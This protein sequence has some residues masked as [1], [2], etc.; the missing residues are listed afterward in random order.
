VVDDQPKVSPARFLRAGA[1]GLM[2]AEPY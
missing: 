1:P 2:P